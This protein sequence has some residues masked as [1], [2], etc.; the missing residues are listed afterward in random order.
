[1]KGDLELVMGHGGT[2]NILRSNPAFLLPVIPECFTWVTQRLTGQ[3]F[4]SSCV[5]NPESVLIT[6][7]RSNKS[8]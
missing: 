5:A 6:D 3:L 7:K 1:M 4:R 8:T 2:L